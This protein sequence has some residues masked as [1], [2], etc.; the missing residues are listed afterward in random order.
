MKMLSLK[1]SLDC[2]WSGLSRRC[3]LIVMIGVSLCLR[4]VFGSGEVDEAKKPGRI[5]G[6][7]AKVASSV[8]TKR[9]YLQRPIDN[10]VSARLYQRYF[11]ALD[12]DHYYFV[13]EDIE[14]FG[15][16]KFL[17]DDFLN[18][19]QMEFPFAVYTL[20]M[21]RVAERMEYIQERLV[22]PFNF[23]IDEGF[24]PDRTDK[25]WSQSIVE[26]DELWR[27]RIKNDVLVRMLREMD[28]KKEGESQVNGVVIGDYSESAENRSIDLRSEIELLVE[29]SKE[30]VLKA[31]E[32]YYERLKEKENLEVVEI[33]LTTLARVYDPHSAYMA[34][35]TKENFD[36]TMKHSLEGI[37]A[38]LTTEEGYVKITEIVSGGPA[39]R[40]GRLQSG[41][42]IVTVAQDGEE[43]ID[44]RNMSMSRVVGL[45]RGPKGT[46]VNLAVI[47][48]GQDAGS[49][50]KNI[51]L[52]RDRINLVD[53]GAR[54]NYITIPLEENAG[55]GD[56]VKDSA[57]IDK[58]KIGVVSLRSF[59]TDFEKRNRGAKDYT[60]STRDVL[61]LI[62]DAKIKNISGLIMDL[63]SNS[64]GSLDEA[65]SLVGLFFDE[66]PV[67]QVQH[68]NGR[69]TVLSDSD[70]STYYDGP[71]IVLVDRFS[72]SAAEIFAAAIQ[73]YQRGLV[74]G[75]NATHGKGTVQ[76]L[77]SLKKLVGNRALLK[78]LK[79]GSLK[80]TTAKF[81]RVNGASTQNIGVTP[82]I[83]IPS[84]RD[85][86]ELSESVLPNA[87]AWDQVAPVRIKS[88]ADLTPVIPF[89][90]ERSENRLKTYSWYG[91]LIKDIDRYGERL[92]K[93]SLPLNI[94][95]RIELKEEDT[96]W[97]KKIRDYK[98]NKPRR[99]SKENLDTVLKEGLAAMLDLI[100]LTS[101]DSARSSP[102]NRVL[103]SAEPSGKL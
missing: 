77:H 101:D 52:I 10:E 45:I 2:N 29:S 66:G 82:D 35:I 71:L 36:I 25:G 16:Y 89:I 68:W 100:D 99:Y 5:D 31:Y 86:M 17:L 20:F 62:Q 91:S 4:T 8:I 21:R 6:L 80:I 14:S 59:Y 34:P 102:T 28:R 24:I 75:D 15:H 22:N 70:P 33:F 103:E 19:G 41:D 44:I 12:P 73:D 49:T 40:D 55:E 79:P 3:Y 53:R 50:P 61:R 9:H 11:E 13:A 97:T 67:V 83:I 38:R 84:F 81:Y 98:L 58:R 54:I 93:N 51:E 1:G 63:R 37:G 46:R 69:K 18:K 43:P 85:K 26:L 95:K 74:I 27:L 94:E 48:A 87:L 88:N 7:I 32:N 39:D 23:Y 57:V 42:V 64:G 56:A 78:T 30:Y 76:T 47:E 92:T 90:Q 72:A 60:S 96:T 65:V